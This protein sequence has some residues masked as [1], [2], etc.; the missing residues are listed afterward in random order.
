MIRKAMAYSVIAALFL[1]YFN[2]PAYGHEERAG[3]RAQ[4]ERILYV[5]KNGGSTYTDI[6]DAIGDATPHTTIIVN[7]GGY[8]FLSVQGKRDLTIRG[9]GSSPE[10]VSVFRLFTYP[11][12]SVTGSSNITISMMTINNLMSSAVI[13]DRSDN[14]T[15]LQCQISGYR[16]NPLSISS[17]ENITIT[18]TRAVASSGSAMVLSGCRKV[19][20][21]FSMFNS[22]SD[23]GTGIKAIGSSDIL[24]GYCLFNVN[25]S[26]S[27][28]FYGDG[29]TNVTLS[30][31]SG[32]YLGRFATI[33]RGDAISLGYDPPEG[34]VVVHSGGRFSVGNRKM[35]FV[36]KMDNSTPVEGADLQM[37]VDGKVVYSTEHYG[38][39]KRKSDVNGRFYETLPPFITRVYDGTNTSR[40]A[41]NDLKVYYGGGDVEREVTLEGV[42]ANSTRPVYVLLPDF[43]APLPPQNVEAEALSEDSVRISFDESNST[44]VVEYR[45]YWNT[46]GAWQLCV[47]TTA[48][49]DYVI[50][51]LRG[52]TEYFFKVVAVDEAGIESQGVYV[53]VTTLPPTRG[54]LSGQAVY[55]GGPMDGEECEGAEVTLYDVTMQEISS[56]VLGEDGLFSFENVTFGEY[57]LRAVPPGA[58]TE[59]GNTSGYTIWEETLNF[60]G[61]MHL[62]VSIPYYEYVPPTEGT[63]SGWVTYSGG[64]LNG[65]GA[66]NVTVK[67]YSGG[68]LVGETITGEGGRYIFRNLTFGSLRITVIP[69]GEVVDGGGV[70]G[71]VRGEIVLNFTA[72]KVLNLT[73]R[74]YEYT[75]PPPPEHPKVRVLDEEGEP[76]EG[77]VVKVSLNGTVYT[78]TTDESGWAVFEDLE[79]EDFPPG[80]E[81]TAEK[82]GYEK[83]SWREGETPPPFRKLQE[84]KGL[85][86]LYILLIIIIVAV[87][88]GAAA[89]VT[90]KRGGAGVEE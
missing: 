82:D 68:N 72:D 26:N 61:R 42:D 21:F 83:I 45:I 78:A 46:S 70:S 15:F 64:P 37:K 3:V 13:V 7:P 48:A 55:S 47:N 87:V 10:D 75:P 60:T 80:A 30:A 44:D 36:R 69:V 90:K 77:V 22:T 6:N 43:E 71:Y 56:L 27:D 63:L 65:N 50:D 67:V 11:S 53:N 41:R 35:V 74:Y 54:E 25:G 18:G 76:V 8:E 12:A 81:F 34:K 31:L 19:S 28:L 52:G 86:A 39:V 59:G 49:G 24:T 88:I 23:G 1:L 32:T 73:I 20:S 79:G 58:V 57:V 5:D 89:Q 84:K 4:E 66:E 2:I 40:Y 16:G 33:I 85:P 17:S 9:N 29:V 14:I 38:G 51:G 62:T